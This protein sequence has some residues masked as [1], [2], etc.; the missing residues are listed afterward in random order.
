MFAQN[1]GNIANVLQSQVDNLNVKSMG[2]SIIGQ[3]RM[4]I[5]QN[6]P[7]PLL[8]KQNVMN[9]QKLSIQSN[10]FISDQADEVE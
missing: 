9:N 8:K 4:S 6:S 7:S 1:T 2:V 5:T 10:T 3:N